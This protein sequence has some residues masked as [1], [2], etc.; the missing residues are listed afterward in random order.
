MGIRAI[1]H[2][3]KTVEQSTQ[4]A[5]LWLGLSIVA[6]PLCQQDAAVENVEPFAKLNQ[7]FRCGG[8]RLCQSAVG[9]EELNLN[10]GKDPF[11]VILLR[12]V[13][14]ADP[15]PD[16]IGQIG[17]DAHPHDKGEHQHLSASGARGPK[18]CCV[19][20]LSPSRHVQLFDTNSVKL[21]DRPAV[22]QFSLVSDVAVI[23]IDNP[24]RPLVAA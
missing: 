19:L 6:H 5:D 16:V 20:H 7:S 23:R 22:D 17:C 14:R 9:L 21:P 12:T 8:L 3:Q 2:R 1:N 13:E 10:L 11:G 18:L 24:K 15:V 4:F